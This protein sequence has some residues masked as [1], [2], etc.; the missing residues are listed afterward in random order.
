V[1][2]K[3]GKAADARREIEEALRAEPFPEAGDARKVLDSLR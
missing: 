2:A 3:Q 1:Y